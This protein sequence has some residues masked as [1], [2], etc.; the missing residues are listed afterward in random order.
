MCEKN[1]VESRSRMSRPA[2]GVHRF[3][4][5]RRSGFTLI[6]LMI[7]IAI[8]AIIAAI[9]IP[10]LIE[11]RKA[12]NEAAAIGTC[13]TAATAQ[14]LFREGNNGDGFLP[15]GGLG[16][17]GLVDQPTAAGAKNGYYFKD[18]VV[19]GTF[20]LRAFPASPLSAGVNFLMLCPDTTPL[21]CSIHYSEGNPSSAS[22]VVPEGAGD[23]A[24]PVPPPSGGTSCETAP[25]D[26]SPMSVQAQEAAQTAI[27]EFVGTTAV[28]LAE[29]YA[30]TAADLAYTLF[31]EGAAAGLSPL[32]AVLT[33]LDNDEDGEL[34]LEE[35]TALPSRQFS[36]G[37]AI[38]GVTGQYGSCEAVCA[39]GGGDAGSCDAD[40]VEAIG[41]AGE[42]ETTLN[43]VALG[44]SSMLDLGIACEEPRGLPLGA[45]AGDPLEFMAEAFDPGAAVPLLGPP[46][47]GVLG[48]FL[49][50]AGLRRSRRS[51]LDTRR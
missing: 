35:L 25:S 44:L 26:V 11:A 19:D 16:D 37:N 38:A 42:L 28:E 17:A 29:A 18:E 1:L 6:E 50:A 12:G 10:N 46:A 51:R 2:S 24:S 30:P 34:R 13:R 14:A 21:D 4:R 5:T 47:A 43:G 36:A 20:S 41:P 7:V 27:F 15:L 23:P 8:I 48:V 40:C 3:S 9:A 22:P 49:V 39:A 31:A 32:L 45:F 33:S